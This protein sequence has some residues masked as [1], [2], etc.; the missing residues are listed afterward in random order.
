[1]SRD[2]R[3]RPLHFRAREIEMTSQMERVENA[4]DQVEHS[5]PLG[6]LL[7]LGAVVIGRGMLAAAMLRDDDPMDGLG[8][9]RPMGLARAAS[10]VSPRVTET[11]GRIRDAAFS[12]AIAKAIDTVD[13]LLPGFREH[14]E[15]A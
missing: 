5:Y 12:F 2:A 13:D 11:L 4:V 1:M 6:S 3:A 9:R 8:T 15:R 14:Y 7:V 10:S